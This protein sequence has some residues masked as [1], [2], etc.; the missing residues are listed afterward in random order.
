[1]RNRNII[2][3]NQNKINVKGT[4][5]SNSFR[6]TENFEAGVENTLNP[7]EEFV[8]YLCIYCCLKI[9]GFENSRSFPQKQ[10]R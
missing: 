5:T 9:L 1:M 3:P 7:T 6:N 10:I 8:N 2:E 4:L